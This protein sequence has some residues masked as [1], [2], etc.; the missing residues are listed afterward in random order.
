MSQNLRLG[1]A[2]AARGIAGNFDNPG[3]ENA[4]VISPADQGQRAPECAAA[5][6]PRWI[7][8]DDH[9]Q[10]SGGSRTVCAPVALK[11]GVTHTGPSDFQAGGPE[12]PFRD[13]LRSLDN[14]SPGAGGID[15]CDV[16]G[17]SRTENSRAHH[18]TTREYN[19]V[20]GFPSLEGG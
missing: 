16:D 12:Y 5:P 3:I 1:S 20:H 4:G 15:H 14:L 8:V 9:D 10:G 18:Q 6:A 2:D 17:R 19:Q 7:R 13:L 11:I